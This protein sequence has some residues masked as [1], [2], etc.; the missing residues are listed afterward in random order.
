MYVHTCILQH[1]AEAK[2]QHENFARKQSVSWKE[3]VSNVHCI[4]YSYT[5]ASFYMQWM[6]VNWLEHKNSNH[7]IYV[8]WPKNLYEKT[9]IIIIIRQ[10]AR[11]QQAKNNAAKNWRA[12]L[13]GGGKDQMKNNIEKVQGDLREH[14]QQRERDDRSKR[15]VGEQQAVMGVQERAHKDRSVRECSRTYMTLYIAHWK[16]QGLLFKAQSTKTGNGPEY[17]ATQKI[18]MYMY[19]KG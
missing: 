11:M 1:E 8:D 18:H 17:K 9:F 19:N 2:L 6:H 7:A 14:Q 15:Q 12:T 4:F 5:S 13:S 3:Q 10:A 16:A